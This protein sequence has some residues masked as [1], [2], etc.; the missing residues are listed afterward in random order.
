MTQQATTLK[1]LAQIRADNREFL[2]KIVGNQGTALGRK[3]F[4]VENNPS[5]AP[6][7]IVYMPHKINEALLAKKQIIQKKLKSNDRKWEAPTDVI[8]TT[9]T[10]S[11]K[12]TPILSQEN[13]KLVETLQWKNGSLKVIPPGAQIGSGVADHSGVGGYFGTIGYM[14]RSKRNKRIKG[15]LTNQHVAMRPGHSL[16]IPGFESSAFR[17]G[18]T[19]EVKEIIPDGEWLEGVDEKFAFV[20][21]D[22][23]FVEV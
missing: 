16:Y 6:C 12:K 17:L 4:H 15:F 14:V 10:M 23:A 3:N 11:N 1:Q 19:R 5:G 9:I 18:I 8:V 7:I 20:R 2:H 21:T 13:Q 22:C